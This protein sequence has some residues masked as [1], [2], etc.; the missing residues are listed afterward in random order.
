MT[1]Q[2]EAKDTRDP[3]DGMGS[4]NDVTPEIEEKVRTALRA[5]TDPELGINIVDLGLVYDVE[6][7]G[8]EAKVT[9]TLTSPGCPAGGQ[10][11][12]GAKDAAETVD[13][14]D[15]AVVSLVWKPFWTPERIDP[16]VRAM[17]GF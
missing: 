15:E 7:E 13:G 1:K 16:A 2:M 12:G 4:G 17:M 11:L 3:M 5:V 14:V 6:V 10:I 9:M 8:S